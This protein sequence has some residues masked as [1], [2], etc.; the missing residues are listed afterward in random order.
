MG[1]KADTQ[2]TEHELTQRHRKF[3]KTHKTGTRTS[4]QILSGTDYKPKKLTQA[5]QHGI[6]FGY[7]AK[8]K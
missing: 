4:K 8:A 5:E 6:K 2:Y 1:R 3:L 7:G